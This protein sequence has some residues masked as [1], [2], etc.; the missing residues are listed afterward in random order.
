[1][2]LLPAGTAVKVAGRGV[3]PRLANA[4][5]HGAHNNNQKKSDV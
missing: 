2:G 5:F 1:M 4:P 3:S